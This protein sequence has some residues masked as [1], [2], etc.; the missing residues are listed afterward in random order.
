MIGNEVELGHIFEC[1]SI[2]LTIAQILY[3]HTI[4]PFEFPIFEALSIGIINNGS[5]RD[6]ITKPIAAQK[7]KG[8]W[9][10]RNDQHK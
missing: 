10:S 4:T 7:Q 1:L 6:Q 8:C 5:V 9:R 2:K 3:F